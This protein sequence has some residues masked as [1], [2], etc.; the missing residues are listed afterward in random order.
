[1]ILGGIDL[2]LAILPSLFGWICTIVLAFLIARR[3]FTDR[4]TGTVAGALAVTFAIASPAFRLITADVML[5]GLGAALTATCLYLYLRAR[6]ERDRGSLWRALAL[7]L[8]VLFFEKSNYWVLTFVPL[9]GRLPVGRPCAI[10]FHGVARQ[11]HN[12][13]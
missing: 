12:D 11:L 5:E 9:C 13:R 6:A 7:A 1:M 10:G 2:R 8:T 3:L 4:Y